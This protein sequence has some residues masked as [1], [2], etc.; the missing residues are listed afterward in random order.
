[1]IARPY[2]ESR[3]QMFQ[4]GLG[5]VTNIVRCFQPHDMQNNTRL[6][7]ENQ[8]LSVCLTSTSDITVSNMLERGLELHRKSTGMAR[9]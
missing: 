7:G 1:M 4:V 9:F 3:S 5:S 2:H 8:S 6:G